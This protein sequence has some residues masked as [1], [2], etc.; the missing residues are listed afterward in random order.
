MTRHTGSD[1]RARELQSIERVA[2]S[3]AN[4]QTGNLSQGES[5]LH[6]RRA[7]RNETVWRHRAE[8]QI[9]NV[10]LFELRVFKSECERT[11]GQRTC[12]RSL[13]GPTAAAYAGGFENLFRFEAESFGY[14]FISD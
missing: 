3:G 13:L 1:E 8:E 4:V 6:G 9:V 5:F 10:F 2:A 7:A 14:L 11:C 12:R